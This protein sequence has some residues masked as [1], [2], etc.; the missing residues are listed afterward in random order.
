MTDVVLKGEF[1]R[2]ARGLKLADGGGMVWSFNAA[3]NTLTGTVSGAGVAWGAITGT[4]SNQTDLQ[5]ALN[6]KQ[7]LDADLT[8]IAALTS[9]ADQMPYSTGAQAWA[10]TGLSAFSRTFLD[11]ATGL[12]SK[13]TQGVHGAST[14]TYV[15]GT[16]TAG[17]ANTAMTVLT[18]TLPANSLAVLGDRIRLRV[19]FFANSVSPIIANLKIGPAASEVTVGTM[20][21]TGGPASGLFEIWVHYIDNTHVNIIE[22]IGGTLGAN[23]ATNVAG[24][25]H[26]AAQ[27]VIVTQNAV[28]GNFI[29]VYGVFVDLLPL[30]VA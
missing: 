8:A 22:Q 3:T 15:S 28:T 14:A 24:F 17:T 29:T 23:T 25:V 30:A 12:I 18:R 27:N 20:T 21:H 4:L 9:A 2:A 10:L 13:K 19:Y 6:A 5:T 1:L 7:P 16:G 11:D 26:N